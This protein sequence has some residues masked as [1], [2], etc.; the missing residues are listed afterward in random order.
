MVDEA[1]MENNSCVNADVQEVNNLSD[2]AIGAMNEDE[3]RRLM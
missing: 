3:R 2:D 1:H